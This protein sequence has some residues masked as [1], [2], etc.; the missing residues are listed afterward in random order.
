[1]N[2]K[3]FGI[4]ILLFSL[5]LK[6]GDLNA[7]EVNKNEPFPVELHVGETFNVCL[8]GEIICPAMS[9]ICD[10]L[11]IIEVV[12]TPDGVG[13]KGIAPGTTLCSAMAGSRGLRRV[14]RITVH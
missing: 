1:M 12:D 10:D 5:F 7:G 6:N 4:L 13:F 11:K 9:P 3:I 8:S 14:F 2:Y